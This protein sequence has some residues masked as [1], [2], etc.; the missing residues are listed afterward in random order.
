MQMSMSLH[1]LASYIVE[2]L[3][4]DLAQEGH[5]TCRCLARP[6]CYPEQL[7]LMTGRPPRPPPA[8]S[9]FCRPQAAQVLQT[10]LRHLIELSPQLLAEI[11]KTICI[12]SLF[13]WSTVLLLGHCLF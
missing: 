2:D 13:D 12:L 10:S 9:R 8:P 6:T 5:F 11:G 3:P 4:V 1:V 7:R